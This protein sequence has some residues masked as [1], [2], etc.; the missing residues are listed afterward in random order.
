MSGLLPR[1]AVVWRHLPGGKVR[2]A[3]AVRAGP[4]GHARIS[5]CGTEAAAARWLEF[6]GI[7]RRHRPECEKC[8]RWLEAS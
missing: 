1:A 3:L 4:Y 2:H 6:G 7:P 8:S 5:L